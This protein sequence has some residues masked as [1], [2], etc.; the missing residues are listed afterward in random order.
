MTSLLG[1]SADAGSLDGLASGAGWAA[2]GGRIADQSTLRRRGLAGHF[3]NT[4]GIGGGA[5]RNISWAWLEGGA[6]GGA[7]VTSD[8]IDLNRLFIRLAS[9]GRVYVVSSSV[10]VHQDGVGCGNSNEESK[11]SDGGALHGVSN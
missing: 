8:T 6:L 5:R 4:F 11:A 2:A 3:Q 10:E 7:E 1:V 9:S